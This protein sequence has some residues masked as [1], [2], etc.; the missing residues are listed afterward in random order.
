MDIGV[1]L[2]CGQG[3]HAGSM[4]HEENEAEIQDNFHLPPLRFITVLIPRLV[5]VVMSPFFD[6]G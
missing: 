3:Q 1:Q 4:Q 5:V 6:P 2:T